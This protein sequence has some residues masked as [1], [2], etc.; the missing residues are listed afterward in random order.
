MEG[1]EKIERGKPSSIFVDVSSERLKIAPRSSVDA[2]SRERARAEMWRRE[3]GLV[4][5]N[6]NSTKHGFMARKCWQLDAF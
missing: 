5:T 4:K 6:L 1:W 2:R 3:I